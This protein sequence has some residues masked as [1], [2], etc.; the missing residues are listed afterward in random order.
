MA[1]IADDAADRAEQLLVLTERLTALTRAETAAVRTRG[2]LE[3]AKTAELQRLSNAYRLEMTRIKQDMELITPAPRAARQRLQ[4]ATDA[5]RRV[6]DEHLEAI[7]A[8]REVTDG[9]V[10]VLAEEI[11]AAQAGP[12]LYGAQGGYGPAQPA[13]GVAVRS[14]A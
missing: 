2:A 6:L 12:R 5:L 4:T 13:G 10:R 11:A 8:A 14:R 3:L 7:A 9:L 1:L